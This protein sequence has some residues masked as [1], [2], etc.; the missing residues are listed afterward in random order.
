M[1]VD[2][3]E[4]L[5]ITW[6]ALGSR[7]AGRCRGLEEAWHCQSLS[8]VHKVMY[9]PVLGECRGVGIRNG[10]AGFGAAY[11]CLH[12]FAQTRTRRVFL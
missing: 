7:I 8:R 10:S 9:A 3:C 11:H 4:K 5:S 6:R 12:P 1:C 2:L